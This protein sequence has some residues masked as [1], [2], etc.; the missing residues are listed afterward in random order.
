MKYYFYEIL[1]VKCFPIHHLFN[2]SSSAFIC[3]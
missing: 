3:F 1:M 2:I